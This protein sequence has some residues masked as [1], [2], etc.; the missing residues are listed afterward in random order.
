MKSLFTKKNYQLVQ[1]SF[2]LG[3]I[4]FFEKRFHNF[5]SPFGLI[6]PYENLVVFTCTPLNS[7]VDPPLFTSNWGW[8]LGNNFCNFCLIS[9]KFNHF[10]LSCN[11]SIG[12]WSANFLMTLSN[13]ITLSCNAFSL[14]YWGKLTRAPL[15][16]IAACFLTADGLIWTSELAFMYSG[17]SNLLNDWCKA[18]SLKQMGTLLDIISC[19]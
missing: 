4:F 7:I 17:G 2:Y 1:W 11:F 16:V 14:M 12:T 5:F 6:M 3:P 18:T 9:T 10:G 13:L 19:G 8:S 15:N